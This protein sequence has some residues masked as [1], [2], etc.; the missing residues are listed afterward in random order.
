M[1]ELE[2]HHREK[3]NPNTTRELTRLVSNLNRLVR[4]ERERYDKYRTTLTDLTHSLKT[5]LA[6]MQSTLR[7]LRGEKISVDEAEPVMLEQISR[8]SQQIGY[9]LHRASMR[10]GGTLLSRE[11]HP[12]APLLDSLT[13]RSQQ[14]LSAQRGQYLARHLAG[15]H[16]CRRAE[17]FYGSDG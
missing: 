7:S 3:L 2:E 17:R 16:F 10:S 1:R 8:I 15:D 6:V 5:P 13:S 4:S 11:L 9:Y 12:I 14:G